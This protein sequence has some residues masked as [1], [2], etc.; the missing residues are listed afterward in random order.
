G[1]LLAAYLRAP[2]GYPMEM[3]DRSGN[4]RNSIALVIDPTYK[5]GDSKDAYRLQV[6]AK[7]IRITGNSGQGLCYGVQTLMQLLPPTIDSKQRVA[8]VDW[9]V[10]GLDITAYA[11]FGWRGLMLDVSRHFFSKDFLK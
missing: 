2:T 10:P 6:D 4:T 3:K 5:A 8:D 11:R 1:D 9:T 7:S